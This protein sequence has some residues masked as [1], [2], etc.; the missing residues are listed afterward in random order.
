MKNEN[1]SKPREGKLNGKQVL[2][3]KLLKAFILTGSKTKEEVW[4]L[5]AKLK[6]CKKI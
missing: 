1:L 4:L 2:S 6:L 5:R 3:M